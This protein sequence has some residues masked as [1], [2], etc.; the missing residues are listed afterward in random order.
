MIVGKRRYTHSYRQ[1]YIYIS[2]DTQTDTQA[3]QFFLKKCLRAPGTKK[4][5][6]E[7]PHGV[8]TLYFVEDCLW[9][10]I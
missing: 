7:N 8:V 6:A 1:T 3:E 4:K 9:Y 5:K 2:F 10:Y